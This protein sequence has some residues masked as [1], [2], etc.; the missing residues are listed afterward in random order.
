LIRNWKILKWI[1]YI[2][3][4]LIFLFCLDKCIS[5]YYSI[6]STKVEKDLAQI[7]KN[8]VEKMI[9]DSIFYSQCDS[10]IKTN[11]VDKAMHLIEKRIR[12]YPEEKPYLIYIQGNVYSHTDNY[13]SAIIKYSNAIILDR[14]MAGAYIGRGLIYMKQNKYDLAI[15]DFED[16]V[17][18]NFDAF[19]Y[20]GNAQEKKGLK[21]EAIKSYNNYLSHY[22]ENK[23]CKLRIEYIKNKK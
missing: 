3:L 17:K 16:A 21:E 18:S 8:E 13:D 6:K 12:L 10:L 15:F 11:H 2:I 14:S 20:L 4:G 1:S 22:P 23:E 9:S 7:S 19:L 5:F